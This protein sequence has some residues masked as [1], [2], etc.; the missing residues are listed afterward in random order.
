M[1]RNGGAMRSVLGFV[2]G[3]S[4]AVS[5]FGVA[6][7][8]APD[9]DPSCVVDPPAA[10]AVSPP[11]GAGRPAEAGAGPDGPPPD[12]ERSIETL[13]L[14]VADL[15]GRLQASDTEVNTLRRV[16]DLCSGEVSSLLGRREELL[17]EL[18]AAAARADDLQGTVD[19]QGIRIA[20]LSTSLA[21]SDQALEAAQA[22][23]AQEIDDLN[24]QLEALRA[25]ILT[26]Q[27]ALTDSEATVSERDLEIA[28][29]T[30]RLNQALVR[31]VEE[32]ARYR[33]EFF[34]RMRTVLRSR[35]DIRVV[36][37][38]FVFQSEVL[39]PSA[40]ARLQPG[41]ADQLAE[42]ADTL[43]ELAAEFPDEVDWILRVD[44]HTDERPISTAAFQ[45]NWELS[46]ARALEV[47]AF[48]EARGV[49]PERLAAAGFGE[50]Q[51][52]DPSGTEEAYR[53][54]RRIELKLDQR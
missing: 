2:I 39:F 52:L 49:P 50:F 9:Q 22:V 36:G 31:R 54:N 40:S 37:D 1:P 7:A 47:V 34:G 24:G 12:H 42:F 4:I 8:Q 14:L 48:L 35:T 13:D 23:A 29:L 19:D 6:T 45:S 30:S 51:P 17:A 10:A 38:R 33:S 18:S 25:E 43:L 46:T 41:G 44:G 26:L 5:G 21:E 16:L 27:Q 28:N 32:L 53:R 20:V 3:V 15:I 11:A